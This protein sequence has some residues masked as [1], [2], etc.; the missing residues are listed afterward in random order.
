M[1]AFDHFST[2]PYIFLAF[3]HRYIHHA[4]SFVLYA[5]TNHGKY[6]VRA[7]P[8]SISVI[9]CDKPIE[10]PFFCEDTYSVFLIRQD[11]VFEKYIYNKF[12][13]ILK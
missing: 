1:L 2:I 3:I 8:W 7:N 5:P 13:K 4:L 10:I 9:N 6:S 11:K 12:S